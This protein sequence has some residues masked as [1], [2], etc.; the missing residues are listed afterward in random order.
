MAEA[1][2]DTALL[3]LA[4]N[5]SYNGNENISV[6]ND[7][8]SVLSI[9]TAS[10]QKIIKTKAIFQNAVTNLKIT[11]NS[12]NLSVIYWEELSKF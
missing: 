4:Q 7:Q 5:Q 12:A 10:G 2:V 9:E 3:K 11:V 6:G 8:C 1:C